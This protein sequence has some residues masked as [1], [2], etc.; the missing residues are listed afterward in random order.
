[1]PIRNPR[2]P[3]AMTV[4]VEQINPTWVRANLSQN[5]WRSWAQDASDNYRRTRD[6]VVVKYAADMA[7]GRWQPNGEALIFDDQGDLR[8]G[9]HRLCAVLMSGATI[10]AVVVRGVRTETQDSMDSGLSRTTADV[11]GFRAIPQ[12]DKMATL[13]NNLVAWGGWADRP[14]GGPLTPTAIRTGEAPDPATR[15]V[16]VTATTR[17]S[18]PRALLVEFTEAHEEEMHAA[19]SAAH[20]LRAKKVPLVPGATVLF[21]AF[22]E[23]PILADRFVAAVAGGAQHTSNGRQATTPEARVLEFYG[24]VRPEHSRMTAEVAV[25]ALM[26]GWQMFKGEQRARVI[27]GSRADLVGD[28]MPALAPPRAGWPL[29]EAETA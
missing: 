11:L 10:H 18:M 12:A 26:A 8:D 27:A 7:A 5:D 20:R 4:E 28:T 15:T 19:L 2:F 17:Q 24:R 16:D 21:H 14:P 9:K 22:R 3:T 6:T 23:D 1:M 29:A 13:A 25:W